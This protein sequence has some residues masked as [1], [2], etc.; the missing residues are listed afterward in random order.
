M[1]PTWRWRA[2]LVLGL[3]AGVLGMHA[4][5]PGGGVVAHQPSHHQPSH[6]QAMKMGADMRGMSAAAITDE[7]VCHGDGHGGHAQHAD[8]SCAS[9][10]VGASYVPP[11]PGAD[12]VGAAIATSDTGHRY[13]PDSPGGGRAPPSLAE[14]QLLRI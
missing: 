12:P 7:F 9:G 8:P 2:L 13:V 5:G 4:L 3:L 10:A 11:A 6:H 1:P 14:L